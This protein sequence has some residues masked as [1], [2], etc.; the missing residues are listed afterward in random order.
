MGAIDVNQIRGVSDQGRILCSKCMGK[1]E[2]Y[3]EDDFIME[4][5]IERDDD[6]LY[7]CDECKQ[8]L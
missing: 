5:D 2:D 8:Q 3:T 6:T 1:V 7:F 4:D